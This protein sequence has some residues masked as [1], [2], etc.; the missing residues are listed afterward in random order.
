[1][2]REQIKESTLE[3]HRTMTQG[4]GGTLA[5][6]LSSNL[7]GQRLKMETYFQKSAKKYWFAGLQ[8]HRVYEITGKAGSGKTHFCEQLILEALANEVKVFCF[9]SQHNFTHGKLEQLLKGRMEENAPVVLPLD[10]I[11]KTVVMLHCLGNELIRTSWQSVIIVDC[12][13]YGVGLVEFE[14]HG[15]YLI[16][17]K[18]L[19]SQLVNKSNTTI[20]YTT[21]SRANLYETTHQK[22]NEPRFRSSLPR[23]WD[24]LSDTTIVLDSP[25]VMDEPSSLKLKVFRRVCFAKSIDNEPIHVL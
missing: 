6:R 17:L 24:S 5:E 20:V 16:E 1:M 23:T 12:L 25:V 7:S 10:S 9:D 22:T 4:R 19:F 11:K 2:S 13:N 3:I 14:R 21:M 15:H 18:K 8:P